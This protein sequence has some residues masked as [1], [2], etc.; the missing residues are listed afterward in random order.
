MQSKTIT[1]VKW[2]WAWQDEKEE[3]WLSKMASQG[4]HLEALVFPTIYR[5]HIG[6]PAEIVYRMDY[7]QLSKQDRQSYLQLFTDSGWEHVGEGGGWV[8]FRRQVNPGDPTEIFSD[9]DSKIQKY[10]R[11][12]MYLVIFLPIWVTVRPNFE[13]D[14]MTILANIILAFYTGMMLLWAVAIINL[15]RR[16]SQLKQSK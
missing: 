12:L 3:A 1:K 15:I 11:V 13:P 10:S 9:A 6:D 4:C 7:P 8:Y 14:E 5:F 16:I 2:F